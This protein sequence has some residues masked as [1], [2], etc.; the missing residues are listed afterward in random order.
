MTR[1]LA[2]LIIQQICSDLGITI[3]ELNS[4][5]K[6]LSLVQIRCIVACSLIKHGLDLYEV[7]DILHRSTRNISYY[8]A[9]YR[10]R[11]R[12]RDFHLLDSALSYRFEIV[13]YLT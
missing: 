12:Y 13:N 5:S 7:A 1:L 4:K 3:E 9:T 2:R 6:K 10:D 8:L 11:I